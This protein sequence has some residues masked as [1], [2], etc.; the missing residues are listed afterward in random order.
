[1]GSMKLPTPSPGNR[2]YDEVTI[3]T[4]SRMVSRAAQPASAQ[5][6]LPGCPQRFE[7]DRSRHLGVALL[8]LDK[9]NRH[10]ANAPAQ[11]GSLEQ[12]FR[13]KRVAAGERRGERQPGQQLAAP[14]AIGARAVTGTKARD[15]P[16]VAVGERRQNDSVQRPVHH[17]DAVEIP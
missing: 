12:H 9:N 4:T 6:E 7:Q 11:A 14:R 3:T 15:E 16:D 13:E 5:D 8:T 1:M 10:L 2:G 17:A